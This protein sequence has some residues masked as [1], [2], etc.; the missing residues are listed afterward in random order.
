MSY[1][2][3]EAGNILVVDKIKE[4]NQNNAGLSKIN[5]LKENVSTG[6]DAITSSYSVDVFGNKEFASST[7]VLEARVMYLGA[8][9]KEF[10]SLDSEFTW[11]DTSKRT[12]HNGR[13]FNA[14]S[15][16]LTDNGKEQTFILQWTH[17]FKGVPKTFKV[18]FSLSIKK[19]VQYL[20]SAESEE[21]K[22]NKNDA[23]WSI[24]IG[25]QIEGTK[26]LWARESSDGGV[27]WIYSRITPKSSGAV[28]VMSQFAYGSSTLNPP[29]T[30]WTDNESNL[31]YNADAP[32]KW[33]RQSVDNG[34]T[35][36]RIWCIDSDLVYAE[37][38]PSPNYY[39][40]SALGVVC[41]EQIMYFKLNTENV[42]SSAKVEW[43]IAPESSLYEIIDSNRYSLSLRILKGYSGEGITV[44][45]M[46]QGCGN[47]HSK[48]DMLKENGGIAEPRYLGKLPAEPVQDTFP[49][50]IEGENK[51]IVKPDGPLHEG[52]SYLPANDITFTDADSGITITV[53]NKDVIR[54][55]SDENKKWENLT[56]AH[57]NYSDIV[58]SIQADVWHSIPENSTAKAQWAY[59]QNIISD[60]IT[61]NVIRVLKYLIGGDAFSEPD[62]ELLDP[63]K[64]G[65]YLDKS[66]NF[67]TSFAD[68]YNVKISSLSEEGRTLLETK[69]GSK[70]LSF[71]STDQAGFFKFSDFYDEIKDLGSSFPATINSD[72]YTY[73]HCDDGSTYIIVSNSGGYGEYH[74]ISPVDGY[75]TVSLFHQSGYGRVEIWSNHTYFGEV[76]LYYNHLSY[77]K[78]NIKISVGDEVWVVDKDS[79]K[80]LTFRIHISCSGFKDIINNGSHNTFNDVIVKTVKMRCYE[81]WDGITAYEN[82]KIPVFSFGE[83]KIAST[84]ILPI[85]INGLY[86]SNYVFRVNNYSAVQTL[87]RDSTENNA[88]Y[89][90]TNSW[91]KFKGTKYDI[92][93]IL[94]NNDDI[95]FYSNG[96][97]YT[98]YLADGYA[99][100]ANITASAEPGL[101]MLDRVIPYDSYS[102]F[103]L[104]SNRIPYIYAGK[105]NSKE[106]VITDSVSL[107]SLEGGLFTSYG[108]VPSKSKPSVVIK[109]CNMGDFRCSLYSDGYCILE[110]Y[111]NGSG[112]K[113]L[114]YGVTFSNLPLI[115]IGDGYRDGCYIDESSYSNCVVNIAGTFLDIRVSGKVDLNGYNTILAKTNTAWG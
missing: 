74:F 82:I 3:N 48:V 78:E 88:E 21:S 59:L 69:K 71:N 36:D 76:T 47:T 46:V 54:R 87:L 58:S 33:I 45:A 108:E 5:T 20:W 40:A 92:S 97:G 62:G 73:E 115:T 96:V 60:Y 107:P 106:L 67:R 14:P 83:S 9:T 19:K 91:I 65:F 41:N 68:L 105:I 12:L 113:T 44:T 2:H 111:V 34:A 90:C 95:T 27:T 103:G 99:L 32:F 75:I 94:R 63:T 110:A 79:H 49:Y 80:N 35:W 30:G 102:S 98:V 100:S 114:N 109:R 64:K 39:Q 93:S 77:I 51:V 8:R 4:L 84:E 37:I 31:V 72:S 7:T 56:T 28:N 81:R 66:G 11:M 23:A 26:Y 6:I 16:I 25:S 38:V 89:L 53:A 112:L 70:A 42:D 104:T 101:L 43:S 18:F 85:S 17:I 13:F 52:D 15:S 22:I 50:Y 57:R 1:R 29:S 55:W 86:L 61:T 10:D 24:A